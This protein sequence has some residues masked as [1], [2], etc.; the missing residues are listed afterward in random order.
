[1]KIVFLNCWHGK[2]L[3][4]LKKF[5]EAHKADTDVFCLQEADATVQ[6]ALDGILRLHTKYTGVKMWKNGEGNIN[7]VSQATYVKQGIEV[8]DTRAVLP[9][10]RDIGI[11]LY[12]HLVVGTKPVHIINLHG[13]PWP[14]KLDTANRI[15]QS[16]AFIE[17]L[18]GA[19]GVRIVGGD[20]NVSPETKS[21]TMF[22]DNDYQDLI[23]DYSIK[24][25]RNHLSWDLHPTKLY[26]SDY[27]FVDGGTT[28]TE[29][30][31]PDIEISD[32]LPMVLE[33]L[34]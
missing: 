12:S 32:H 2:L 34:L 31:V 23:R 20:L 17:C 16:E 14:G 21:V 8:V 18:R 3:E 7:E 13:Y 19:Q 11:G 6:E 33:I 26:Y 29:F 9:E 5:I 1:V 30:S 27:V 4:P 24:T 22:S 28:V 10:R 25:T 15:E